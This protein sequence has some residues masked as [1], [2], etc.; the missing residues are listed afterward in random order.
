MKLLE[1]G[2][3]DL[4]YVGREVVCPCCGSK[5]KLE[6]GDAIDHL[7]DVGVVGRAHWIATF[8]CINCDY[9][10]TFRNT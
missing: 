6:L 5:L 3:K 8:R 4:W 9:D 1:K 7:C 10:M 2:E